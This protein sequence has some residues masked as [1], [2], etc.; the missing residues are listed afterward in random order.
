MQFLAY[1]EKHYRRLFNQELLQPEHHISIDSGKN[2]FLRSSFL[3]FSGVS[4]AI[5]CIL[6]KQLNLANFRWFKS[7]YLI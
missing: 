2:L 6:S 3:N 1:I 4:L 5:F 7:I